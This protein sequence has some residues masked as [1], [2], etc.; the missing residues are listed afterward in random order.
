M[1]GNETLSPLSSLPSLRRRL[2]GNDRRADNPSV[3]AQAGRD[4]LD[5]LTG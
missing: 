5:A 1:T 4:D 3:V 2:R